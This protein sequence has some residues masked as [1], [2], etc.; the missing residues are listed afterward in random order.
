[1]VRAC[2]CVCVCLCGQAPTGNI[3]WTEAQ[4]S[5]PIYAPSLFSH[6]DPAIR[7]LRSCAR[8]L[9]CPG[10]GVRARPKWA[11]STGTFLPAGQQLLWC[12]SL[13][14]GLP[15]LLVVVSVLLLQDHAK[16]CTSLDQSHLLC[17]HHAHREGGR[18]L[19]CHD[20]LPL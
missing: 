3:T 19:P 17:A 6:K 11:G 8:H 13:I 12:A 7:P 2:V 15:L 16:W 9:L 14:R 20:C 10:L 4:A 1:V 5:P 18:D